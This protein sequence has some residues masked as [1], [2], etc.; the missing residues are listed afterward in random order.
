MNLVDV[1]QE[2]VLGSTLGA[3]GVAERI[4]KKYRVL[5]GELNSESENFKLG[6]DLLI[7]L[8]SA[9]KDDAPLHY[10]AKSMGGVYVKLPEVASCDRNIIKV[11][12][13]FGEFIAA[14]GDGISDGNLSSDEKAKISKEGHEAI[15]VIQELLCSLD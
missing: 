6:A 3:Q 13:E 4:G 9:C 2:M 7:P 15:T 8:M 1:V 11:V 5:L 14:Y 10:I 12:K